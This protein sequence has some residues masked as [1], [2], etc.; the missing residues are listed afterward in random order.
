MYECCNIVVRC[1]VDVTE[2]FKVEV[3]QGLAL[4]PFLFA[5]VTDEVR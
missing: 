5:M 4:S 2:E 3:H 1:A